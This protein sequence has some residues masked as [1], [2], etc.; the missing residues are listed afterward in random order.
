MA[1]R[2]WFRYLAAASLV[3]GLVA[4]V[5]YTASTSPP[6]KKINPRSPV[7]ASQSRYILISGVMTCVEGCDDG[8]DPDAKVQSLPTVLDSVSVYTLPPDTLPPADTP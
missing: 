1:G 5:D 4:C 2:R 3:V 6:A 7:G 8:D